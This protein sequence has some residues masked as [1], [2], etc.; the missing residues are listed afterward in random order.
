VVVPLLPDPP[1]VTVSQG[2]EALTEL[3]QVLTL[4]A[5]TVAV[6]V[7]AADDSDAGEGDC[8]TIATVGG[9]ALPACATDKVTGVAP[10][11]VTVIVAT[12]DA[13]PVFEVAA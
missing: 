13:A 5:V 2:D 6:P 11:A 8:A 7:C 1:P 4:A 9:G 3:V 10:A 12:R